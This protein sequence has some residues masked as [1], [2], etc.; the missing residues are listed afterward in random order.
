M[1]CIVFEA[2]LSLSIDERNIF[3]C[4]VLKKKYRNLET[5]NDRLRHSYLILRNIAFP[6]TTTLNDQKNRDTFLSGKQNF[7]YL[8]TN[9]GLPPNLGRQLKTKSIKNKTKNT[10]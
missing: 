9:N 1:S 10:L 4:D 3:W 5:V 8:T 7:I 2:N 6:A